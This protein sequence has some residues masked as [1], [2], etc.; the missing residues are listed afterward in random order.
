MPTKIY[1]KNGINSKILKIYNA[2]KEN[3]LKLILEIQSQ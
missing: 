2:K 3:K 1:H